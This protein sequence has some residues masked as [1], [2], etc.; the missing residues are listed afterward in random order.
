MWGWFRPSGRRMPGTPPRRLGLSTLAF[1]AYLTTTGCGSISVNDNTPPPPAPPSYNQVSDSLPTG[2]RHDLAVLGVEF[3]PALD[4]DRILNHEPVNLV[5]GVSNQGNRR[6]TAVVVK[7]DLWNAAGTQRLLHSEQK[8][9][10]IAA[11]NVVPVRMTNTTTPPFL[12]RYRLTVEIV[13][14]PGETN[15]QNNVRTLDLMVISAH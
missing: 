9:D 13:A 11:G 8:I 14:V 7:A 1:A 15:T 12:Q 5:V 10:S 6:E 4:V 3:D 2:P